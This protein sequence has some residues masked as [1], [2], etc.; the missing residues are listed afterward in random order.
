VSRLSQRLYES[1]PYLIDAKSDLF[2]EPFR[3]DNDLL[4]LIRLPRAKA[5]VKILKISLS[6]NLV[7]HLSSS[8][9]PLLPFTTIEFASLPDFDALVDVSCIQYQSSRPSQNLTLTLI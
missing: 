3:K 5:T 7:D 9:E 6:G 1:L 4:L 2:T 8:R